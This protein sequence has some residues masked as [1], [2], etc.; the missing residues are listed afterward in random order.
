MNH[1][2]AVGTGSLSMQSTPISITKA[3][4]FVI[5]PYVLPVAQ[6]PFARNERV[7]EMTATGW[8][9]QV[10]PPMGNIGIF[11]AVHPIG[12]FPVPGL[13]HAESRSC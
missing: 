1:T 6:D 9:T 10:A 3:K 8:A 2:I 7:F 13:H 5:I 11:D 4:V 12:H